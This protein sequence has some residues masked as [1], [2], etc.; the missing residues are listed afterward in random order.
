MEIPILKRRFV[1]KSRIHR[2]STFFQ[3]IF[4]GLINRSKN[5]CIPG[6]LKIVEMALKMACGPMCVS[7]CEIFQYDIFKLFQ[8]VGLIAIE[9]IESMLTHL[10]QKIKTLGTQG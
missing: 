1:A 10:N 3:R 8:T 7:Y 2:K 4:C 9:S 5:E 6:A